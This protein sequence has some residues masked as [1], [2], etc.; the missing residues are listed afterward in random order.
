MMAQ[1]EALGELGRQS[2][3]ARSLGSAFVADVL[4]AAERQLH[5]GPRTAALIENWPGDTASAAVALRF[6]AGVHAL[7]RSG[8]VPRLTALFRREHADYDG[9][10]ADALREGDDFIADWMSTPT[11]TNEVARASALAAA[12]M[13]LSRDI[14]KPV[15]LLE[16]G[17]SCGLNLNL[18]RYRHE[19]GGVTAGDPDSEVTLQPAWQGSPPPAEP[20]Q[21]VQARGV[22][23]DPLDP[24][25]AVTRERLLSF[26]WADQPARMARL[27][28]ALQV[29]RSFAP[30]VERGNALDWLPRQ[31]AA[32]QPA[33][34]CRV[35]MHSMVEQYFQ[36]ADRERF[37]LFLEQ[38]GKGAT[39]ERPMARI[40]FEWTAARDEVQLT[41]TQWPSGSTKLLAICHPYGEWI[42][43]LG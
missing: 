5:S 12:L 11:Q 41:L 23:L 17:S 4:D 16:L 21:I 3:I 25:S 15:E 40:S 9:A 19:L 33:G 26:I 31:M 37:E 10:L 6:N 36:E 32:P 43:W 1:V 22:D 18:A 20:L 30:Q 34:V 7:A 27:D 38:A 42:R 8:R 39:I 14:G 24:M 28:A 2:A 35:V 13:V 29:A